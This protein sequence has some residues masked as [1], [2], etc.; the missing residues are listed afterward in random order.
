[1]ENSDGGSDVIG[2]VSDSDGQ[3][4]K[5]T[6]TLPLHLDSDDETLEEKRSEEPV[7]LKEKKSESITSESEWKTVTDMEFNVSLLKGRLFRKAMEPQRPIAP[8]KRKHEEATCSELSKTLMV[9]PSGNLEKTDIGQLKVK[10]PFKKQ[11]T[12]KEFV[13]K[14]RKDDSEKPRYRK[15]L[16]VKMGKKYIGIQSQGNINQRTR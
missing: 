11:D 16:S 9:K 13:I 4:V 8:Q 2:S 5:K 12:E 10:F 15:P 7:T 3:E 14:C 1:M 6:V